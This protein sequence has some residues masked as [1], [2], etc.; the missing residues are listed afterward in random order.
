MRILLLSLLLLCGCATHHDSVPAAPDSKVGPDSA[1]GRS[2]APT[3]QQQLSTARA[4]VAEKRSGEADQTLRHLL[5]SKDFPLLSGAQQHAAVSLAAAVA[6]QLRDAPRALSLAQWACSMDGNTA[7]DWLVRVL[8]ANGAGNPHEA[9][10]A[11]TVVAKRSPQELRR[12]EEM[13]NLRPAM[14]GLEGLEGSD[15]DRFV[16]LGALFDAG[17]RD[18]AEGTSEW[19]RDLALLQLGHGKPDDATATIA[20]ISDPYIAIS[21]DADNRFAPLGKRLDVVEVN[22]RAIEAAT[23]VTQRPTNK[24][25][26]VIRLAA[27]LMSS[28]RYPEVVGL[29]DS[30]IEFRDSH[31]EVAGKELFEDYD[32]QWAW[33]LDFR[34]QALYGLTRWDAA[35]TQLDAASRIPEMGRPNID[36]VLELASMQEELRRPDEALVTLTRMDKTIVTPFYRMSY[37][38]LNVAIAVQRH[39]QA[40]LAESLKYMDAHRADAPSAY[41]EALLVTG[42]NDAG[43]KLLIARL[44]NPLQRYD[45]LLAVQRYAEEPGPPLLQARR[46]S[47]N[48]LIERH[49]VLAAIRRVGVISQYPLMRRDY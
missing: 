28:Q 6:V 2:A 29:T 40:R 47:W 44:Q 37:E 17:F 13:Q 38:E 24:L 5:G 39:D 31:P 15:E 3:P 8:A 10:H 25:R 32:S 4:Q 43:A 49:E 41:Q 21:I 9:A 27:L 11:L 1:G 19:W 7:A 36:Q 18:Q 16:V 23:A 35:V 14:E 30:V 42:D 22:R 33:L 26:P 20:H 48:A 34:A 12:L 46:R 45:A